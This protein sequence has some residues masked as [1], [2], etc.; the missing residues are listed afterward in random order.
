[1]KNLV[2]L[3]GH[4]GRDPETRSLDGGNEVTTLNLATTESYKD[5]SGEWQKST[6]WHRVV[7]WGQR[8]TQAAKYQKADLLTIEGKL[9]TRKWKDKEGQE[10]YTTEINANSLRLIYRKEEN[11]P[12]PAGASEAPA[13]GG[14]DLPF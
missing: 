6:E 8:S 1:M 5:K 2:I 3:I 9:V 7:C 10:R 12:E 11:Q 14:D 4:L 13:V